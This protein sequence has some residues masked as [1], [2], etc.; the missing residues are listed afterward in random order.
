MTK[1]AKKINVSVV[2]HLKYLKLSTINTDW[3]WCQ[4]YQV[5]CQC[6]NYYIIRS[7]ILSTFDRLFYLFMLKDLFFENCSDLV[8]FSDFPKAVKRLLKNDILMFRTASSVLHILP[9]AGLY[10]FLP[11][12]L[13][14]QFRL[15]AHTA[16]MIS[17][18]RFV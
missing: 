8:F 14:S 18:K 2:R 12:Y 13:E 16:N 4:F 6:N 3:P 9:I 5:Q 1:Q 11:K 15:A 17:G 10:T 7:F